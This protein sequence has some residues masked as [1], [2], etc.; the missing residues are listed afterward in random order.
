MYKIGREKWLERFLDVNG[1]RSFKLV[2]KDDPWQD[3]YIQRDGRAVEVSPLGSQS[4]LETDLNLLPLDWFP[5][6]RSQYHSAG[7]SRSSLSRP[8][9]RR[10]DANDYL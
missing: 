1:T 4:T 10:M 8:T 2:M 3:L 7:R 6:Y 5:F 9:F